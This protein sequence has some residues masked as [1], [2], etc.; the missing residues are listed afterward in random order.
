[1]APVGSQ[2]ATFQQHLRFHRSSGHPAIPSGLITVTFSSVTGCTIPVIGNDKVSLRDTSNIISGSGATASPA[3]TLGFVLITGSYGSSLRIFIPSSN[4]TVYFPAD[5]NTV[6]PPLPSQMGFAKLFT[7]SNEF[8]AVKDTYGAMSVSCSMS[9]IFN[10]GLQLLFLSTVVE[11]H[12][13]GGTIS[14]YTGAQWYNFLATSGNSWAR[15][16]YPDSARSTAVTLT[17][18]KDGTIVGKSIGPDC[19]DP[20]A[21]RVNRR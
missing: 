3:A 20:N 13:Q 10:G 4:G 11:C 21:I 14:G 7:I 6:Y 12:N 15:S 2:W 8:K 16:Q 18:L 9:D 17:V 1:M 19:R 5:Y